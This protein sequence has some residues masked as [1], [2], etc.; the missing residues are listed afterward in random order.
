VISSTCAAPHLSSTSTLRHFKLLSWPPHTEGDE[1]SHSSR[2]LRCRIPDADELKASSTFSKEA[3]E[4]TIATGRE[5]DCSPSGGGRRDWPTASAGAHAL[6]DRGVWKTHYEGGIR[7][8]YTPHIGR[9]GS[10][11]KSGHL[12]FYKDSMYSPMDIDGVITTQA[13]ELPFPHMI[14]KTSCLFR[15]LPLRWAELGTVYR[16]EQAGCCTGSCGARLHPGRRPHLLYSRQIDGEIRPA[17]RFPWTC[18]RRSASANSR[19]S[20]PFA[21]GEILPNTRSDQCG[22]WR[23]HRL[24]ALN[25]RS[26]EYHRQRGE[27]VFYGRKSTIRSRMRWPTC[28]ANASVDSTIRNVST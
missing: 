21:T 11:R 27:A 3:Q 18:S 4:R 26:L 9:N 7:T 13:D 8:L 10:G 17:A 23:R 20:F 1:T 14:Y 19:S 2:D 16:Y 24:N 12:I 25:A 5:L 28:S 22:Q 6:P 15:E